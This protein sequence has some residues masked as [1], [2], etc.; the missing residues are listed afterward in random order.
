M[1]LESFLRRFILIA[2]EISDRGSREGRGA[3]S[4]AGRVVDRGGC[5][6]REEAPLVEQDEPQ[7]ILI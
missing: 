2:D 3:C 6:N 5:V 7:P 1:L 4:Y